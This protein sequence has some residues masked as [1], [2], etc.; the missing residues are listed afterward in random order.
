MIDYEKIRAWRSDDVRHTYTAK[1][2][3]LYALGVGIGTDPLDDKQLRFIYE[4]RDLV[5][6]PTMVAVVASPGAWMR[7]RSE[8]GIDFLKLVHGEQSVQLHAPLPPAATLIGRSRVVRLV[9]KG[10][11]KGA[12]MHVEKQL[13]DEATQQHIATAEQVLFLRGDGG[14]SKDGGGDD[15]APAA[16]ATPDTPPDQV[17]ELPTRA[18]QAALYRLSGDLNPLHIDPVVASKAGFARPILHGLATYGIACHGVVK[19]FCDYDPTR[20]TS[21]R[22]RLSSPVYPG[23]TIRLECWRVGN[24]IAF[25]GRV[26][27]RDVVVLMHGRAAL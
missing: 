8:L 1:D 16:P 25:R 22:A 21:I 13:I 11:G 26:P 6:L 23:E 20:L 9:D 18:D 15:P 2:T 12:V 19:A 4:Q 10:E 14:F 24:E 5:A 27:E 17:L 3:I 7:D